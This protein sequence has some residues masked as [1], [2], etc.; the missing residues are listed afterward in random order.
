MAPPKNYF[1]DRLVLLLVTIS[2]FLAILGGVVILL[3]FNPGRNEGYIVQ[4]RDCSNLL[5]VSRFKV[6]HASDMVAFILF[7]LLVTGIN[8]ALSMRV[9]GAHRQFAVTILSLGVLL[10]V[11]AIIV[12]NALLILS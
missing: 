8:I 5:N 11:L 9:Y 6:G 3:N 12:S 4:C 1:H 7:L 10:L 2:A